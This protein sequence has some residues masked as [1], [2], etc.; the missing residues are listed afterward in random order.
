MPFQ[1]GNKLGGRTKGAENKVPKAVKVNA[2]DRVE[3]VDAELTSLKV[4]LREQAIANPPWFYEK[5][6]AKILPKGVEVSGPEGGPIQ[7]MIEV[8]LIANRKDQG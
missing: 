4:G 1:K 3:Q 2:K 6:W 7:T 8:V 5:I